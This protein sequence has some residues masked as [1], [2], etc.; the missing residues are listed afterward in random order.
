MNL[1]GKLLQL[2]RDQRGQAMV[3]Y[4]SITFFILV[5]TAVGFAV[6]PIPGNGNHSMTLAQALYASLQT[7]VDSFYYSLHLVAP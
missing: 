6:F 5:A 1:L 2:L 4:S 7:Y 3:E